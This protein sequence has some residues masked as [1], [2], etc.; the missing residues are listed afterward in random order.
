M[1]NP[2]WHFLAGK[3]L[4]SIFCSYALLWSFSWHMMLIRNSLWRNYSTSRWHTGLRNM[5]LIPALQWG[6]GGVVLSRGTGTWDTCHP[7][8]VYGKREAPFFSCVRKVILEQT[9]GPFCLW[10]QT[11]SA[12]LPNRDYVNF[13]LYCQVCSC[14]SFKRS[15][16]IIVTGAV[17]S[18]YCI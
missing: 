10:T 4:L 16:E 11:N 15:T 18:F 3:P 12:E 14:S 2:M 5:N 17:T 9:P 8:I 7:S 1:K 13:R 6:W